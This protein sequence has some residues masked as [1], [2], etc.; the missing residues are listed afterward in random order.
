MG[1]GGT[2]NCPGG[3]DVWGYY[4]RSGSFGTIAAW[5]PNTVWH[6]NFWNDNLQTF[7]PD[8]DPGCP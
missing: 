7:C 5:F 6:G 4:P 2:W 3:S 8:R 1:G